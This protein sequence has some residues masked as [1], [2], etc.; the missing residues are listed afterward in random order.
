[1]AIIATSYVIFSVYYISWLPE[2]TKTDFVKIDF[3]KFTYIY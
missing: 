2:N 1:M 3:L